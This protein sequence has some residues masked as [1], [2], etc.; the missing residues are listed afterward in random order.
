MKLNVPRF[1]SPAPMCVFCRLVNVMPLDPGE[2][3]VPV[4]SVHESLCIHETWN[5]PAACALKTGLLGGVAV[6]CKTAD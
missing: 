4:P 6:S 2:P 3:G 1:S 5:D